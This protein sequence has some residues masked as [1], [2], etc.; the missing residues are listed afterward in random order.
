CR[1]DRAET[2]RARALRRSNGGT[3]HGGSVLETVPAR[4][5]RVVCSR[6]I[7]RPMNLRAGA[8]ACLV[9]L[10]V[11]VRSGSAVADA[12]RSRVALVR[13]PD[14]DRLLREV[15]TRLKAELHEAGFDVV[16]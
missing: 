9:A 5:P 14:A 16:E 1:S 7:A 6:V 3:G 13:S 15:S 12:P 11:L 2:R 10:S 8:A 4:R